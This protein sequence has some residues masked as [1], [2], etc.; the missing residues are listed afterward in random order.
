MAAP[1]MA[2]VLIAVSALTAIG[3]AGCGSTATP[4][5]TKPATTTAAAATTSTASVA[6]TVPVSVVTSV[7]LPT[8][9]ATTTPV[10]ATRSQAQYLQD[11][12]A[13]DAY[14]ASIHSAT[15]AQLDEL[16]N[17]VTVNAGEL[18]EQ[19]WPR[20]AQ[21]DVDNLATALYA[22]ASDLR[23]GTVTGQPSVF[24]DAKLVRADLD[25]AAPKES[26]QW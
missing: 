4:S 24:A 26:N 14:T 7:P 18:R 15:Y 16:A 2:T 13:P 3:A 12:A 11:V 9:A 17:L 1:W 8:V 23:A 5:G 22:L 20:I 6:S 10:P 19:S 21:A 25:L